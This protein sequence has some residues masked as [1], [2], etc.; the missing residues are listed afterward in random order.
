VSDVLVRGVEA[1]DTPFDFGMTV[2][3]VDG[4]DVVGD[5]RYRPG[6]GGACGYLP[7]TTDR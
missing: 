3:E 1:M 6:R 5:R 2:R 4:I 7:L